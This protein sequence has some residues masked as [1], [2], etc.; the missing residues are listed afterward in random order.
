MYGLGASN[1][2][3]ESELEWHEEHATKVTR[4]AAGSSECS[5]TDRLLPVIVATAFR[6]LHHTRKK[7]RSHGL[8]HE[9]GE[10][11]DTA[12]PTLARPLRAGE[13]QRLAAVATGGF[14][15]GV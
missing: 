6:Y 4:E 12:L 5:N 7:S 11:K 2:G 8:K 14:D 13:V 1:F 3:G 9:H 10:G 15:C